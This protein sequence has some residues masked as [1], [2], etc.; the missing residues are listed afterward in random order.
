MAIVKFA[1]IC[2]NPKCEKRSPEYTPWMS[3]RSCGA[4]VCNEC[5]EPFTVHEDSRDVDGVAI[6]TLDCLCGECL[7]TEGMD[8][9]CDTA[10]GARLGYSLNS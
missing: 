2:D 5:A 9:H 4:H 10:W 8:E 1:M 7:E 3:C 6:S